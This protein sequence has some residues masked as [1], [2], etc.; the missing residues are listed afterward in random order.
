VPTYGSLF[1]GIDGLGLGIHRSGFECKFQVEID[2]F[3][4]L[5]LEKHWPS[6]PRFKDVKSFPPANWK[7]VNEGA[8]YKVDLLCG[9]FP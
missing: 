2:E 9:G 3:C 6:V 4:N 7:G 1:S 5:V 8:D